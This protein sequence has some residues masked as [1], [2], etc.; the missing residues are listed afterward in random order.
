MAMITVCSK[1]RTGLIIE[2]PKRSDVK[3]TIAGIN[4]SKIIGATHVSTLI[5]QELWGAWEAENKNFAAL[6]SGA[7]FVVKVQSDER[8]AAKDHESV[9][10]GLEPLLKKGDS[11]T[12]STGVSEIN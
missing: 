5:D 9:K 6:K 3:C 1:L 11:R 8:V 2:H 10:T 4:S 12:R 7:L